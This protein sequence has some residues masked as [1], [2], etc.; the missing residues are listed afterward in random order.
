[1][2][3]GNMVGEGLFRDHVNEYLKIKYRRAS[4]F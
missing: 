1:M 3:P 2:G 4:E